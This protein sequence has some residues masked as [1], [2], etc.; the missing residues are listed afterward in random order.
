MQRFVFIL[1]IILLPFSVFSQDW[2]SFTDTAGMFTAK[3][4]ADWKNKI[5]ANNRVFFTSPPQT[6]TDD[7]FENININVSE[8]DEYYGNG[9]K[10][11]DLFPSTMDAIKEEFKEFTDEGTTFFKW[12]KIRAVEVKYSGYSKSDDALKVRV[13]QWFC[14]YKSRFYL[15]TYVSKFDDTF[16]TET[17][18][19]ILKSI[20]FK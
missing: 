3:Y 11:D 8:N 14:Y 5:K 13:V 16:H 9:A 6:E 2:K 7:F 18:R 15:A 20:V 17:A 10:V 4:P 12:N 19:K 1:I